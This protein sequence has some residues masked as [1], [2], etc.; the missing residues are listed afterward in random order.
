M[1]MFQALVSARQDGTTRGCRWRAREWSRAVRVAG[2]QR[3]ALASTLPFA[4]GGKFAP[5]GSHFLEPCG[6]VAQ[7]CRHPLELPG[8]A[9]ERHDREL[10]RDPTPVFAQPR[11]S[12]QVTVSI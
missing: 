10:E 12:Q 3:R 7:D 9:S 6:D 11:H 4:C 5:E 2:L 1:E 8:V